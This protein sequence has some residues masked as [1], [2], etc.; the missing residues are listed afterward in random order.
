MNKILVSL[1]VLFTLV[2][3]Y[4]LGFYVRAGVPWS[5]NASIFLIILSSGAFGGL[6]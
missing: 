5:E 2:I 3:G 6:L 4:F 1:S